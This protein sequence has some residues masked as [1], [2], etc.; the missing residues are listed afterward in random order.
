M[1]FLV[2]TFD[3]VMIW[4]WFLHMKSLQGNCKIVCI[5]LF[6][7]FIFFFCDVDIFKFFNKL[8]EKKKILEPPLYAI[9]ESNGLDKIELMLCM[10]KF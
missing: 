4:C 8:L 3:V 7:L 10:S 5:C 9:V 1:Y 2:S 6:Y